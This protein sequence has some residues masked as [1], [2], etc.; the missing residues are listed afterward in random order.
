MFV[1][2]AGHQRSGTTLLSQLCRGHPDMAI[3]LELACLQGLDLPTTEYAIHIL[4]RAARSQAP[5]V[6]LH[7][8]KPRPSG[9]AAT[10][11]P[12]SALR[13]E[14]VRWANL[15]FAT[16]HLARLILSR[17]RPT[18]A[19]AMETALRGAFPKAR[20][21]GDKWPDYI[22]QL[23][24][25]TREPNV[26]CVVI[27]RDARDVASST[28][29]RVRTV[30]G[31]RVW[32]RSINTAEKVADRWVYA[33]TVMERYAS[34]CHIIRY[35]NLVL[36]PAETLTKLSEWLDVNPDGFPSQI[37]RASSM[38]K[39]RSGLTPEEMQTVIEIAG[40]TMERLGYEL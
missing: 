2:I 28:L 36:W 18:S 11:N 31:K 8:L 19:T 3:T 15:G 6:P 5:F 39:Y 7:F 17:D 27:Y 24:E 9:P 40:P 29:E 37:V 32:T 23:D 1:A 38:G 35:E 16:S 10:F 22:W 34:A 12:R 33:M 21:V 14:I 25:L 30:W 13:R 26:R 4:G 20:I